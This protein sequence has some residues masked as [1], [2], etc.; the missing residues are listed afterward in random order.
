MNETKI[1]WADYTTNPVKG[2]CPMACW[3]CYARRL[4][5]RFGWD[6]A[7][8]FE[9]EEIQNCYLLLMRM[10]P[11]TRVFVGSTIELFGD[12]VE[13]EWLEEIFAYVRAL[14][15]HTFIFLTKQPERL[16]RWNP[17][18]ANCWV[19][20]TVTDE[21]SMIRACTL[22]YVDAPVRF[23]S[24]EPLLGDINGAL[25]PDKER[26]TKNTFIPDW[27]IIGAMTGPGSKHYQPQLEWIEQIEDAAVCH[28]IPVFEKDNL[29]PIIGCEPRREWPDCMYTPL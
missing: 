24:F 13:P 7:I 12:W 29:I 3:Y 19:G 2:L 8:R 16:A 23:I 11:H 21:Q 22:Q 14:P 28:G 10:R 1:E 25:W 9:P 5:D 27:V 18:P 17:W 6:T 26:V 15:E 4:Y 20:A